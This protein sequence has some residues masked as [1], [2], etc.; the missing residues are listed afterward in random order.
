MA[1][2]PPLAPG[3]EAF[4]AFFRRA[5]LDHDGRISGAEA[6]A[7]F[8]GSNLP[9]RTL[10][11]IWTY[12][13]HNRTGFLGRPEFYNALRLV[14][15]AQSGRELTPDIVKAALYGPAAAKIPA[16]QINPVS[17]PAAQM[18]PVPTLTSQ[19]SSM[20]PASN[21]MGIMRPSASPNP[22]FGPTQM[23]PNL[24]LN[25]QQLPAQGMNTIRPP[26]A[27]NAAALLPAQGVGQGLPGAVNEGGP[28]L[29]TSNTLNIS[30]DWIGGR[31]SGAS[32]SLTSQ[33]SN[34]G[35]SPSTNLDGFGLGLSS[36][37]SGLAPSAQTPSALTSSV[38]SKLQY[39][40]PLTQPTEKDAKALVVAGNGFKSDSLFGGDMFSATPHTKPE[41]TVANFSV[42]NLSNSSTLSGA[43]TSVMP[44][45]VNSLQST[46]SLSLGVSPGQGTQTFVKQTQ[47][48]VIPNTSA[49]TISNISTGPVNSATVQ[50]WPRITQSDIQKYTAVFVKVDKDRDGKITGEEARNLFL[51]WRLPREV[52]KQV[53]DLSDQDNDSM[54][55]LRE[56]CTALY[57][58]E[59]YREGRPLPAVLPNEL[60]LD[61]TLP[62]ATSQPP[63]A[64]G[65]SSWQPTPV[66]LPQQ[67]V[68]AGRPPVVPTS[69]RNAA[70]QAKSRL[71]VDSDVEPIQ[72]KSKVPVLE[73]HL[74]NQLSKEEQSALNSKLQEATDADKKVQELEKEILDAKEK[75]EF[76]RTKMQELIFYKSK[77]DNRLNEITERASADKREVES[78]AKKYEEKCRK[79]GDVAS[80]L[81]IEEATFRDLQER[82]LEL[83]NS[84]VKMEQGG[85]ADGQLQ[86]RANQIQSDLEELVKTLNE[87]CKQYGL[88]AKPTS[89]IELPFGWQ[90]GIEEGAADWDDVWDKFEDADFTIIKELTVEVEKVAVSAK[91]KPAISSSAETSVDEASLHAPSPKADS[92]SEKPPNIP[93]HI[94]ETEGP[95]AHSEDESSKSPAASPTKSALETQSHEHNSSQLGPSDFSPRTK[96]TH[97]DHVGAESTISSEKYADEPSW[98]ATFD[99]SD[100][101]DSVW[102]FNSFST[103]EVDHERNGPSS[104][105]GYGDSGLNPIKTGSPSAASVYG[106]DKGPFFD[107]VPSTPLFNSN[108]PRFTDGLDDHS[109]DSFSRFDSFNMHDS[110]LFTPRDN[111]LT[112]FDSMRSTTDSGFFPSRD[113]FARFDSFRSTADSGIFP[114]HE[115]FTR[116][117]SFKSTADH[118]RGFPSFDDADPFGSTGPFKAS[119]SH[120]SPRRDS[121]SWSAF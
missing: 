7:F 72:Q 6:V 79:S 103:K 106:R 38:P 32:T 39:S 17:S 54:L 46:P 18:N 8:Q 120:N 74:V 69:G 85:T 115:S 55:S 91:P 99:A 13:D 100:D 109:F 3:A 112:R 88:R 2:R 24:S 71:Q 11:Q 40:A 93:E 95:N 65:G 51:S 78:L 4:D 116:F 114:Q 119:G 76:Y 9:Q 92:K 35:I 66:G 113:S 70:M 43:Q 84:I 31:S 58:M 22:G 36:T 62:T 63:Y 37:S 96:E 110:G 45:Q 57:L 90:P 80:K 118:N 87:R 14:T 50:S 94:A 56:F 75:F 41:T 82:K 15:V 19:A 73:A 25:Q 108:S 64:Y 102:G 5:D 59:K 20:V 98:G 29:P 117:D 44:G 16:P 67:G 111:T 26:Q 1:A 105:F 21:Q 121:D 104:F 101:T 52:L 49:S 42:N 68:S 23:P 107:S 27:P 33:V 89:L 81:T 77:C 10:A 30:T 97:S 86:G 53:W 34:R 28:R 47:Q 61:G 60:R 83:Y 48:T 12:A